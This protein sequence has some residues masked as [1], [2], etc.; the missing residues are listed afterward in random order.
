M[1][2][3]AQPEKHKNSRTQELEHSR[4]Q[5]E[6]TVSRA[7]VRIAASCILEFLSARVLEFFYKRLSPC[8]IRILIEHFRRGPEVHLR[9][10]AQSV[11]ADFTNDGPGGGLDRC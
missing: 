1:D 11:A 8:L 2:D 4:T 10:G 7:E 5:E 6:P 9:N 3:I